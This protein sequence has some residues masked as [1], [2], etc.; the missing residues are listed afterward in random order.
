MYSQR[1]GCLSPLALFTAALTVI[2]LIGAG[3]LSGSSMFSPGALNAQAGEALGGVSSHAETGKECARCHAAP[4]SG[5]TMAGRCFACHK[6]IQQDIA[7]AATL[8]GAFLAQNIAYT[9]HDC[10]TEHTGPGGELTLFDPVSFPH[11]ATGF[12]LAGHAFLEENI[13]FTCTDCHTTSL[14]RFDPQVCTECHRSLDAAYTAAH[15]LDFGA[16]CLACHDGLD[17]YGDFDHTLTDFALS[18]AHQEATCSGCHM[19]ARTV[20]EL[21][22]TPAVCE[23]CHLDEDAHAGK[24][25]VQCGV[26]HT[27]TAWKPAEFDHSL[28]DFK[29]EGKHAQVACEDCHTDG[30]TGTPQDCFACHQTGRYPR[31]AVRHCL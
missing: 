5:E 6:D 16:D 31:R 21:Q 11:A 4:W 28:A 15:L 1:L 23:A 3:I 30:Y 9:C 7:D 8:H 10:H 20:A 22:N 14:T 29:L 12:D 27:S 17:R 13:P 25:G 26:C 18:G 24:F 19:N 2:M